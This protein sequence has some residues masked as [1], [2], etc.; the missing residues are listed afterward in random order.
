MLEARVEEKLVPVM[1][2]L[3]P[4]APLVGEKVVMVGAVGAGSTVASV[5]EICV[6]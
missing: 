3:S 1:V 5:T 6:E 4:T 2:T